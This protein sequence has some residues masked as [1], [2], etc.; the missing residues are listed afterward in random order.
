MLIKE[1]DGAGVCG[2][3]IDLRLNVGGNMWPMLAGVGPLLGDSVFGSFVSNQPQGVPWHYSQ[4]HAWPGLS[5]AIGDGP[6]VV[7]GVG[8]LPPYRVREPLAPVALLI[9]RR[10][11]S[12]G[13]AT[14]LAFLGR[15]NVRTFGD[16]T[17]GFNSANSGFKLSD[18][19]TMVITV[20]YSRD[21]LGRA[22]ALSVAP[23][24]LVRNSPDANLDAPL[25]HA[26][27]W[28]SAHPMCAHRP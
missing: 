17:A 8:S 19:A 3:V 1:L 15:P 11:A 2:W 12:S 5:S 14:L 27:A 9:G 16:S 7:V 6:A 24:E 20:G 18:G 23:D 10:T 25:D 28:L 4:G 13:E 21:R 26:L 22:Y